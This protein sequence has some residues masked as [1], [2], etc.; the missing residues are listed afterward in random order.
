[1]AGHRSG[2]VVWAEAGKDTAAARRFYDARA[3]DVSALLDRRAS[4]AQRCRL[5]G[6][7]ALARTVPNAATKSSPPS[8]SASQTAAWRA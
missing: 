4:W 8:A 1:V 5:P 3:A 2:K 6:F 7:V